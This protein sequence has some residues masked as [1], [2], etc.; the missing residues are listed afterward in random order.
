MPVTTIRTTRV[1]DVPY[2][3]HRLAAVTTIRTTR[4]R[5]VPYLVHR[6]AAVTTIRTTRGVL[7]VPYT[8][9]RPD[10]G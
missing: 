10:A 8:V 3:V 5:D 4:E 7:T 6:L 2:L 9:Y 1:R